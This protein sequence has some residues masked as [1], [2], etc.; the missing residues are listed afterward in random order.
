MVV[1]VEYAFLQNFLLDG[2]LLWLA[3]KASKH[4][5]SPLRLLLSAVLGGAFALL[6]PLLSL[7]AGLSLLLKTAVG[8]LL[9]LMAF[10]RVRN[11]KEG[12]RC[13]MSVLFFFLFTFGFGGALTGVDENFPLQR[14]T[15]TGVL[16]GFAVLTLFSL[17]LV[18]KLY[19][20][21]AIYR[22]VYDCTVYVGEKKAKIRGFFDS[23]NLAMKNGLPVC[24]L[25]ADIL[26]DL[27]GNEIVFGA[28]EGGQVCEEMVISTQAGERRVPLYRGYL[29]VN[30]GE[31]SAK[32]EVYFA[33]SANMIA[34]EYKILL[35][36][37]IWE[38][39]G[40]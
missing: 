36:S 2:G 4:P 30:F 29:Q 7:S 22:H 10:G 19:A 33:R 23:G 37:R 21:R 1:Y 32:K 39:E 28:V 25:S 14:R 11:K 13:A 16:I 27:C 38:G 35:N 8:I 24:F 31:N 15:G 3:M 26:Y 6:F 34:R 9:P 18:E 5:P 17:F 12:G 40:V 20:K